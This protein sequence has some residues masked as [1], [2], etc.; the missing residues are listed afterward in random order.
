[1]NLKE[2]VEELAVEKYGHATALSFD[3]DGVRVWN[4]KGECVLEQKGKTQM[5]A[6]RELKKKLRSTAAD[7]EDQLT[8]SIDVIKMSH[9][10]AESGA[11][12]IDEVKMAA[13]KKKATAAKT[14]KP[15]RE[16][17]VVAVEGARGH[18]LL[19]RFSD[20]EYATLKS[21]AEKAGLPMSQFVRDSCGLK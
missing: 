16:A 2:R 20:S 4:Q 11:L 3:K 12:P 10:A 18:K 5:G 21:K 15:K 14:T 6:L 7:L 8:E 13:K 1:M 9:P 17:S 19:F